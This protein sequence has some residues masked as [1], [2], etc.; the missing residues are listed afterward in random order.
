LVKKGENEKMDLNELNSWI[1]T[2]DGRAWL[3]GQKTG[4]LNKQQEL[5]KQIKDGNAALTD[6]G[7]RLAA[8]E[9]SLSEERAFIERSLID[10][11]LK[12]LLKNAGVMDIAIPQVIPMLKNAY[13][14]SIVA[15]SL[16]RT[17][18]G[19]LK[20][21]DGTEKQG[22]LHDVVTNW[23]KTP[24]AKQITINRDSGGGATG[25]KTTATPKQDLSGLSGH[26]LA[27]M[28]DSDFNTL[29]QNEL[30]KEKTL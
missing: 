7:Q 22:D 15:N 27:S 28:S 26:D 17:A 18:W 29:R 8:A 2:D 25:S 24:E 16:D 19:V 11:T 6:S 1:K 3:D 20:E 13:S 14:I 5:L 21:H 30:N 10:D 4:L 12:A 23:L 9:G